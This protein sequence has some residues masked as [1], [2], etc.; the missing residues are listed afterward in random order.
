MS[1]RC[2]WGISTPSFTLIGEA[3]DTANSGVLAQVLE[4]WNIL[5]GRHREGSSGPFFQAF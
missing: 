4:V 5:I 3:E 1:A 2:F